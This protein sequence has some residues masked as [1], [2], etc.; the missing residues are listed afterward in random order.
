MD[1]GSLTLY[2]TKGALLA[3]VKLDQLDYTCVLH[4]KSRVYRT[5]S[6]LTDISN[7]LDSFAN[8]FLTSNSTIH[9]KFLEWVT[10]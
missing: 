1:R 9:L 3:S 5:T 10:L 7:Y 2:L 6:N 4:W 8:Y